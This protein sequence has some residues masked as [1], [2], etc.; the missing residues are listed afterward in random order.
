MLPPPPSPTLPFTQHGG[1]GGSQQLGTVVGGEVPGERG[2][3]SGE[4]P[5]PA[6]TLL[7]DHRVTESRSP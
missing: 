6:Q 2:A 7:W 4:T 5:P 1:G 3:S